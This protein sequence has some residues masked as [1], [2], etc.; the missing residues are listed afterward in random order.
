MKFRTIKIWQSSYRE[1][2]EIAGKQAESMA[3][4][5]DE[6]VKYLKRKYLKQ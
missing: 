2:K 1:L 5:F 3:K 4:L 6:A